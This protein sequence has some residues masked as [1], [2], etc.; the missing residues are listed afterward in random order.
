MNIE[1]SKSDE[2]FRSEVRQFFE[3]D[4]PA[5]IKHKLSQG[6]SLTKADF[7]ESERALA[8][9][10][11]S[12]P[13]WPQEFGGPGWSLIQRYIF[14]EEL[15]RAGAAKVIPMGLLYL[16]PVIYTFGSEQQK[17]RWLPDI[18]NSKTF[19]AQGY[20]EP[21]AGSDLASLRCRGDLVDNHYVV[22]GEKTW[23]SYAQYA[24]WIFCLVRTDPG[25]SR[26]EGISFL[27]IDMST[28]GVS[29]HP[30]T[31]IDG[32]HHLN[33]VTF[34]DVV[35]PVENRI[36]EEGKGWHYAT[37]LLTHER[38]SYAQ[39]G[40][41]KQL[42]RRLR[43][44]AGE[45]PGVCGSLLDDPLFSQRLAQAE[46]NLLSLEYTTLRVLGSVAGGGAPGN[47]SSILKVMATE[48][49]QTISTLYL[50]VAGHHG[51]AEFDDGVTPQW[52][53]ELGF[54]EDAAPGVSRY[55]FDRSQSIYGGTNEIQRNLIAKHVLG[56]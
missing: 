1:F 27:C 18:L 32:K 43:R 33:R 21:N 47:E 49:A 7:Q 34:D 48:C 9:R 36:G 19:W 15:E 51:I 10:G 31:S 52:A 17:A 42:L 11:W 16:G 22:S 23:S 35:V 8:T 39:I 4:Y 20:S 30:I 37:Y 2:S 46:I 55:L 50:E 25:S 3:R 40:K 24:D 41:K 6:H 13:G 12:A 54:P 28:P 56:L 29:V 53:A 38:T 44:I 5:H 26:H 14:D 45:A